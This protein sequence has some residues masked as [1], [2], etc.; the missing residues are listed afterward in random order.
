MFRDLF[1]QVSSLFSWR[2]PIRDGEIT[3]VGVRYDDFAKGYRLAV[4][5]KFD[6]GSDG[7]YTGESL[8]PLSL[9]SRDVMNMNEQFRIGSSIPVRYRPDD[10]SVNMLDRNA[11]QVLDGL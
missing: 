2:W 8:S 10:P 6:V 1:D 7:P 9:D 11:W 3:A 4:L 5:Y